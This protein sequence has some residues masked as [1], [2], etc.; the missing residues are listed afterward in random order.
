MLN[1]AHEVSLRYKTHPIP[2]WTDKLPLAADVRRVLLTHIKGHAIEEKNETV[3]VATQCETKWDLDKFLRVCLNIWKKMDAIYTTELREVY[4]QFFTLEEEHAARDAALGLPAR[5]G[6][7]RRAPTDSDSSESGDEKET[8]AR[9][10]TKKKPSCYAPDDEAGN[11]L[12]RHERLCSFV[13][14]AQGLA[15]T[16]ESS[17]AVRVRLKRSRPPTQLA[18]TP[19]SP[20]PLSTQE[21]TAPA[22]AYLRSLGQSAR[23]LA[24]RRSEIVDNAVQQG[25]QQA[26]AKENAVLA[27]RASSHRSRRVAARAYLRHAAST[28]QLAVSTWRELWHH[29]AVGSSPADA[30]YRRLKRKPTVKRLRSMRKPLRSPR[31]QVQPGQLPGVSLTTF[32]SMMHHLL[33]SNHK[34][35]AK[36]PPEFLRLLFR[37][38]RLL[39]LLLCLLH[40]GTHTVSAHFALSGW[41][42]VTSTAMSQALVVT[43][44]EHTCQPTAKAI[45][46]TRLVPTSRRGVSCACVECTEWCRRSV[47]TPSCSFHLTFIICSSPQL[48]FF[49]TS[50]A[51]CPTSVV[52]P[53]FL[54]RECAYPRQ[55]VRAYCL[56]SFR[57][58]L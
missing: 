46:K 12:L 18:P 49:P 4:K 13:K 31:Q 2:L 30:V 47:I 36:L 8:I 52:T 7:S 5:H 43:R 56:V 23:R 9:R 10:P 54:F 38:V 21:R 32:L 1:S 33:P 37:Q 25:L 27:R 44:Q 16:E 19:S 45:R 42:V 6:A 29:H 58:A 39:V 20:P 57:V 24:L 34:V 48:A 55:C 28:G 14:H 15:E 35:M 51:C 26:K 40:H 41:L 50:R 3:R 17:A 22:A 53:L 11:A